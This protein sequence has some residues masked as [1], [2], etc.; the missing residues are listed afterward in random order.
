M[1]KNKYFA[2]YVSGTAGRLLKLIE[3][4]SVILDHTKLVVND[5]VENRRL[6]QS[7][8]AR[9]IDYIEID[10]NKLELKG[11][12]KN[13]YLSDV[14]LNKFI[15]KKIDYCFCFGGRIL[16]GDLLNVYRNKIINFHPSLLPM[17]PG[18]K[19]ID[20]ALSKNVHLL[21]NTAHFIDEGVDTGAII[22]Q[23]VLPRQNYTDYNSLLDLQLPMIEQIFDWIIEERLFVSDNRV[24]I[25]NANYGSAVFYP[26]CET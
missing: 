20:Q 7:L 6:R 21:G 5:K 9:G 23:S 24:A 22:M 25:K 12:Q 13:E 10:Y 14:L 18:E 19:S 8:I 2:F 16:K 3:H 1:Q 17:F 15:E 4:R 26:Q 11:E